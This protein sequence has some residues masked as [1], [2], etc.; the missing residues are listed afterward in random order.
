MPDGGVKGV[1]KFVE[2]HVD[3]HVLVIVLAI[4][5]SQAEE[6]LLL[7]DG[8]GLL[9]LAIGDEGSSRINFNHL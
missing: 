8:I 9:S 3:E 6:H 1:G 4:L 7:V 5:I 2:R